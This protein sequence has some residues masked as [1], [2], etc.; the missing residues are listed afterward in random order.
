MRQF[1][2]LKIK[3]GPL[4]IF[5]M[6]VLGTENIQKQRNQY[7][8]TSKVNRLLQLSW[9]FIFPVNKAKLEVSHYRITGAW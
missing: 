2:Y 5:I 8:S 1:K 4:S 6:V 3:I 7:Y 9:D